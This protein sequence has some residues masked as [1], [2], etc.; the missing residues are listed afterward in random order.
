MTI[1]SLLQTQI[2]YE[3][4]LESVTGPL[5]S[6]FIRWANDAIELWAKLHIDYYKGDIA[7]S[8]ATIG[9]AP[10]YTVT[11]DGTD[12]YKLTVT[13]PPADTVLSGASISLNGIYGVARSVSTGVI[14]TQTTTHGMA[15]GTATIL[16][17]SVIHDSTRVT[18]SRPR[19]TKGKWTTQSGDC[20][21]MLY[22]KPEYFWSHP[23][24]P[25]PSDIYPSFY[26][27]TGTQFLINTTWPLTNTF[28]VSIPVYKWPTAVATTTNSLD[29]PQSL[30]ALVQQYIIES[31]KNA[32]P[33]YK[34]D[35]LDFV[36]GQIIRQNEY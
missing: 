9:V 21:E 36:I 18:I 11:V 29:C 15:T 12:P 32:T 13:S 30:V 22:V 10:T 27:W 28:D 24:L 23:D 8:P 33:G 26:T 7:Y 4:G 35:R 31:Y 3:L 25:N 19:R 14:R 5:S 1:M 6:R 17:R 34:T 2:Q 20:G 16:Q